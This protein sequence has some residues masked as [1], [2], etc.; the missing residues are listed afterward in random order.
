MTIAGARCCS[1]LGYCHGRQGEGFGRAELASHWW[2]GSPQVAGCRARTSSQASRWTSRDETTAS[3]PKQSRP[4]SVPTRSVR[5]ESGG[6]R[7]RRWHFCYS[8]KG[9]VRARAWE[10]REP[11]VSIGADR[12]LE[13][14]DRRRLPKVWRLGAAAG[15]PVLM[16]RVSRL[17]ERLPGLQRRSRGRSRRLLSASRRRYRRAR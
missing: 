5:A 13:A 16:R 3:W 6:G 17:V 14:T 8:S 12:M 9:A 15:T 1:S 11:A 4:A 7:R 10:R 2:W